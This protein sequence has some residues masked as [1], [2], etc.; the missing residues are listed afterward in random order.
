[1]FSA[2][3]AVRAENAARIAAEAI[4]KSLP[5]RLVGP[6]PSP[7]ER[8]AGRYRFEVVLRDA[9][10]KV[11]PWKLAPLLKTLRIPSGVRRKVDVDPMDMM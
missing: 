11:L 8:L 1:L 7:L 2:K 5:V 3:E 4:A 9:D 6:V 10:R